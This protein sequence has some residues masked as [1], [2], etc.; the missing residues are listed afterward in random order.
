M[1]RFF[2]ILCAL[3]FFFHCSVKPLENA[4]DISSSLFFKTFLLNAVVSGNA[5]ICG[6]AIFLPQP[7]ILNLGSKAIL[8]TGFLIGEMD[9]STSGV[10]VSLDGGPFVDAQISGTQWKFQLPA[11]G[12]PSTIPSTGV[13]KDWSLHTIS[14]RSTSGSNRSLPVSISVQ[15]GNNKDIDGDGYPDALIGSQVVNKVR[16]YLSLGKNRGLSSVVTTINGVSG[17]GYSVV[18]GDF[19]GDGY[20]DGA[21]AGS[22]SNFALYL[23]KG[24][25]APGLSTTSIS[26]TTVGNG[27]LNLTVGDINGDGFSDLMVG[28][29]YNGGNVGNVYTFLSN[30]IIGQGVTFQQQLN[31]P[32]VAGSTQFYGYAVALGDVNGDGKSDAMIAAVG[33]VQIGASFVYLSQGNTFTTYS[34]TFPGSVTNQWYA[35][36]IFATDMNRDGLSDMI[37]GAYQEPAGAAGRI[38]VYSSN[39]GILSNVINSPVL[40]TAASSMGTSAGTGD[41]NGDG[42][43]DIFGGGY[44]YTGAQ[45]SQGSVTTF[46]SLS[47]T[48]IS[49]TSL[50]FLTNPVNMGEMGMAIGSADIDGDGFCDALLGAPSS[51]GGTNIGKVYL[52]FSDGS[53]GYTSVPQTMTDPDATGT[54][55]SSVDL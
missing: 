33:S 1:N 19:D 46:L 45:P 25:S 55:G 26:P 42:F 23:S 49:P 29:P 10:Q 32:A 2:Y 39:A 21:A 8:N 51:V 30:G 52:Y 9:A 17:L 7:K 50:N 18:L 16:A 40:G 44:T 15:K 37:V 34:Q 27:I 35:N 36:S 31:N 41:I 13:W 54:F 22:A 43:L 20:A 3:P 24:A 47:S 12:V 4:C 6:A 38:Y 53:A 11:A 14:V 48:G 28:S 5:S